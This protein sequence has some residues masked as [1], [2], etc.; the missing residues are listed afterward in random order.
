MNDRKRLTILYIASDVRSGSTLLDNLLG[1][2]PDISGIG[3]VRHIYSFLHQGEYGSEVSWKC[4]CGKELASCPVWVQTKKNYEMNTGQPFGEFDIKIGYPQRG[5]LYH[6]WMWLSFLASRKELKRKLLDKAYQPQR[7][8]EIGQEAHAI[9]QG[10][11]DSV[12]TSIIV[13]SS[14]RASQLYALLKAKPN[15]VDLKVIH[16]VRDGRAVLYS[17]MARANQYRDSKTEFHLFP[18]T[19]S[20]VYH[21]LKIQSLLKLLP[22]EDSIRVRYEDLCLDPPGTLQRICA[23]LRIKFHPDM[24]HL[25]REGKHNVG[26]SPHRYQWDPKTPIQLDTRWKDNLPLRF[27]FLYWLLSGPLHK[28]YGY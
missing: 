8:V 20:W 4:T 26:G 3:E 15:W 1:N 16:L 28:Y 9:I 7:M 17:K 2:H 11:A 25:S 22:P 6:A 10:F 24:L 5:K 13:D 21:N 23:N 12:S 27:R 14:K 19:R 18:A